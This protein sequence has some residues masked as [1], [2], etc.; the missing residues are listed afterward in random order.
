MQDNSYRDQF[1]VSQSSIKDFQFKSPKKWKEIWID[2]RIDISKKDET[3][4]MGSLIDTILFSPDELSSRFYI[5]EEKLPSKALASIIKAYYNKLNE[6]N[7]E[8]LMINEYIPQL[9]EIP[10]LNL[11]IEANTS[12]L[13]EC[14]NHYCYK[15]GDEEKCGWNTGWK[16]DTRINSLIKNGAD[17]FKS[18]VQAKN[19]KIISHSMN[20]EAL[21]LVDILRK[22]EDVKDYFVP[23]D[24]NELLF[25]L[26][27]FI[28]YPILGTNKFI[29]LKGALDIV[30]INHI[31]KTIQIIDF[32]S[33]Y[34]AFNF[35]SSI[36]QFGYCDQLSYYNF[37]LKEWIAQDC[38]YKSYCEYKFIPP[39]NIVI[40]ISDKEPYIYEYEWSDISLAENGNKDFLFDLYQTN[41]HNSKIKKGWKKTLD[42]ISWH[43]SNNL[44]DKPKELYE[45]KKIK[46]NLLNS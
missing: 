17:Y 44:W 10:V 36:K 15:D 37:L 43:W 5:G 38:N 18:L 21:D 46:I 31:G 33:S 25:Q 13:L 26:E 12:I 16:D 19:R 40:D 1:G 28:N 22:H 14:A 45:N 41:N 35:I 29:P 7:A 9:V 34:S 4:I 11:T 23:S 6:Q 42:E 20:I 24:N 27:I 39:I 32:K 8:A 30:R 3:F 2:K